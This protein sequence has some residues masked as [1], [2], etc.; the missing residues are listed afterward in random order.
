MTLPT[1]AISLYDVNIELG[2]AGGST[3]D[4][5]D[6]SVRNLA[7]QPSGATDMNALR[8]KSALSMSIA[9]V[10]S[11]GTAGT[12]RSQTQNTI[13]VTIT[14]G[15]GTS[16]NWTSTGEASA[17]FVSGQ[18]TNQVI[19]RGPSYPNIQAQTSQSETVTVTFTVNGVGRTLTAYPSFTIQ[20]F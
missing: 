6:A 20:Q 9:L 2:R 7:G 16:F 19:M 17:T 18:G 5:N 3:I 15:T 10:R 12:G 13:T 11:S 4:M 8:G 1:G 14:G